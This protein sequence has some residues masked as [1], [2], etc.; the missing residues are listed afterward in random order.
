MDT[1]ATEVKDH[2]EQAGDQVEN[3]EVTT[4]APAEPKSE[5]TDTEA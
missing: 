1:T 3:A 4:E 5:D 2:A